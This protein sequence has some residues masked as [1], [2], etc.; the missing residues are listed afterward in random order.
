M[1]DNNQAETHEHDHDI[2]DRVATWQSADSEEIR[3]IGYGVY[4]GNFILDDTA[5]GVTSK[6][7]LALGFPVP[8]PRIKLD[9]GETIWGTE[10]WWCAEQEYKDGLVDFEGKIVEVPLEDI[11]NQHRDA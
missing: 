9:S 7:V 4:E 11:R 10:C 1:T 5:V 3:F 2:G 6:K 8:V